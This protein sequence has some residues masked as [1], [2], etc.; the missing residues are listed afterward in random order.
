MYGPDEPFPTAG[1]RGKFVP[2]E[3][4]PPA[5]LP[6]ADYPLVLNTGRLLEHWHTGSMTRRAEVLDTLEPDAFVE[7]HPSDAKRLGIAPGAWVRVASRRGEVRTTLRVSERTSPGSVFMPFC[8]REAAANLLTSDAL[9]PVGK[10]PEFK[11]CAVRVT[12][13]ASPARAPAPN[14]KGAHPAAR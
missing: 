6:D 12:A 4:L 3:V 8:F 2:A 10:I 13:D 11:Y 5:E 14:G 1:G 7:L 9:D